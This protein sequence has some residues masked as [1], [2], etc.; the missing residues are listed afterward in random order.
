MRLKVTALGLAPPSV[1]QNRKFFRAM[2]KD[3]IER[4][5]QWFMI[6]S[7]HVLW[8]KVLLR[9]PESVTIRPFV[10]PINPLKRQVP[11]VSLSEIHMLCAIFPIITNRAGFCFILQNMIKDNMEEGCHMPKG[12]VFSSIPGVLPHFPPP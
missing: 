2:T 1:S 9:R 4:F 6:R 10:I 5:D 7:V 3:L 8:G 11:I 12:T